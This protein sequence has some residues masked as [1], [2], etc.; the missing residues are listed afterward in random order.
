MSLS[1]RAFVS[2]A[3]QAALAVPAVQALSACATSADLASM[4]LQAT[5]GSPVALPP[6]FT[7]VAFGQTGEAMT[8]GLFTPSNHDGMATFPLAGD[9]SRCVIVRNH[10]I[11]PAR[12]VTGAFGRDHGLAAAFDRA[13][14]YDFTADGRPLLGG[15][16]TM[17]YNLRA[18]RLES[19]FLSLA[20]TA[21]NC[22]G[23]PT[24]WG[25]WLT[26]EETQETPGA[27]AGRMHGYVFEVPAAATGPVAPIALEAMGRFRHEACAVDPHT[28]IVYETEDDREGLFYRFLPNTRGELAHGGRLQALMIRQ[29]PGV[30]TR[31]WAGAPAIGVGQTFKAT[32]VDLAD[33]TAPDGDLRLRGRVA[34]GA[35]FA[36]GEGVCTAVENGRIAIY[37]VCTSGGAAERGQVWRLAPNTDGDDDLTL[38]AESTGEAMF[39]M[40]DNIVAA[41]WGDLVLCEDGSG[42]N[43]VRGLTPNGVVYPIMRNVLN[44]SE[45]CGATF[46]PDGSTLFV[47]IQ[48]PGITVA[49]SGPWSDL[50]RA[51]RRG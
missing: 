36:R 3:T 45:M 10:E 6:G 38:F 33:V 8:D 26:C 51:A 32:W 44:D 40:I 2:R 30:D 21:T 20:G 24:P 25:S 1:R 13:K 17:V 11:G 43:F 29:Q 50:A 5:E 37:F 35:V 14:I 4:G 22:A 19:S 34:G 46:S 39:D 49:V 28:G 48:N 7:A 27:N 42:E 31:N 23:G 18:K 16:T 41:P 15:T 47:N 12:T 9:P